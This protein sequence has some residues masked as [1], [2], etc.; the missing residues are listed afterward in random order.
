MATVSR[1]TLSGGRCERL[2]LD[3][4]AELAELADEAPGSYLDGT[5]FEVVDAKILMR[6]T[7]FQHVVDRGEQRCGDGASGDFLA[8]LAAYPMEQRS[9]VLIS[10]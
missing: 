5:L 2:K 1:M 8:S 4:E 7:I 6:G 10:P 3:L 9:V